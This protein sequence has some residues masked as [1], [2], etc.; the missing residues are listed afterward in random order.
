MCLLNRD[1]R[2][3]PCD[4]TL[5]DTV[6]PPLRRPVPRRLRRRLRRRQQPRRRACAAALVAHARVAAVRDGVGAVERRV[7]A[8]VDRGRRRRARQE[9]RRR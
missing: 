4:T 1:T 7:E 3:A 2:N 8:R 9:R 5:S 6:Q